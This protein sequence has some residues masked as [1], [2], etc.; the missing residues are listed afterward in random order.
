[1][2]VCREPTRER[3]NKQARKSA[4]HSRA[5]TQKRWRELSLT[6]DVIGWENSRF[7]AD[8]AR[9]PVSYRRRQFDDLLAFEGQVAGFARLKGVE[10]HSSTHCHLW[11]TTPADAAIENSNWKFKIQIEN[12]NYT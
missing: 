3:A 9:P 5:R 8:A 10:R 11:P 4:R 12:S 7:V 1:M 2:H 6:A